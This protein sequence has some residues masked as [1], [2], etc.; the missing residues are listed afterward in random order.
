MNLRDKD[1][2]RR[3]DTSAVPKVSFLRRFHCICRHVAVSLIC[4]LCRRVALSLICRRVAVS[5]ICIL[6]YDLPCVTHGKRLSHL[7]HVLHMV[8]L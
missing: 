5:L 4:P 6:T 1:N 7:Y 3:K 8:N 2:L